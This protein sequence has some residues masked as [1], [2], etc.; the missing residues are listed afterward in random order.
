[1]TT[2]K[3]I[4]LAG[5]AGTRLHPADPVGLQATAADLRQADD[6]LPAVHAACWPAS[7]TSS[8]SP[9]RRIHRASSNCSATAA[10]GASTCSYAV[11]PSPDGLAQAFIIGEDFIGS[12]P[13][14][15]RSRRQHLLRPRTSTT[16]S[17]MPTCDRRAPPSSATTC[18]TPSATVSSSST[19]PARS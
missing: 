18:T 1:M 12:E 8:S 13:F 6:L 14:R 16:F 7:R 11:Q 4:I 17:A 10:S 19:R 9:P 15:A 3:G 5:G 2:R